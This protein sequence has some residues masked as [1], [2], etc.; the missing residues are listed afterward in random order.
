MLERIAKAYSE[1]LYDTD[2]PRALRVVQDALDSGMA[3]ETIVFEVVLPTIESMVDSVS[4]NFDT[5]LAQHF[6]TSQISAE[7]V[8]EMVGHFTQPPTMI[9]HVVIGTSP[10]D[11]H[12]LGKRIV[13]GCLKAA[14]IGVTDLGLNVPAERFVNEAVARSADVIGISSMMVHTARGDNGCLGVRRLLRE[15]G[16]EDRIKIAVGGA[17]YRFDHDLYKHVGADGWSGSALDA[18]PLIKRLI[19]EVKR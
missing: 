15:R 13:I 19:G 2:R 4:M 10:G 12:G 14:M 7:V 18:A 17:P 5:S 9:G 8:D 1:S 6:M 16:L 11:F 3:P